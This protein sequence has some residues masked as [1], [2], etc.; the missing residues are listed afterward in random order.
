MPRGSSATTAPSSSSYRHS[1][2]SFEAPL[3]IIGVGGSLAVVG[4]VPVVITLSLGINTSA[5]IIGVGFIGFGVLI[6]LP[7]MCW[8]IVSH[9]YN[10]RFWRRAQSRSA[11]QEEALVLSDVVTVG[12]YGGTEES[13]KPTTNKQQAEW[14]TTMMT[15]TTSTATT[16][17]TATTATTTTTATS[18][19]IDFTV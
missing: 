6:F 14:Y 5:T 8:C 11:E 3:V 1:S 12:D 19:A 15:T 13:R 17:T 7:G 16:T 18:L 4:T 10:Y 2:E 9:I